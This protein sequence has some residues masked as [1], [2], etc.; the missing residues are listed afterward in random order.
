[1]NNVITYKYNIG[2]TVQIKER[3]FSTASSGLKELTGK[4]V[5]IVDRRFYGDPCYKFA[6]LEESGWFTEGTIKCKINPYVI[7][8]G[9]SRD[10]L[11]PIASAPSKETAIGMAKAVQSEYSYIEVTY[12]PEEDEDVNDIVY[13]HYEEVK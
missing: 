9:D 13:M 4:V 3:F 6:G 2:D 10:D 12:M 8:V 5:I 11:E 7:F 1:M